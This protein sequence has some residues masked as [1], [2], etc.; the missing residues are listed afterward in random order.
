MPGAG[1]DHQVLWLDVAVRDV[2]P[3]EKLHRL[4]KLAGDL[5]VYQ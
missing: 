2:L 5:E 1:L 3:V 4:E